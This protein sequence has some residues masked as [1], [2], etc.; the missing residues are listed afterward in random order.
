VDYPEFNWS[1][2]IE[3][4]TRAAAPDDEKKLASRLIEFARGQERV[5]TATTATLRAPVA[6]GI[7]FSQ[8]FADKLLSAEDLAAVHKAT[9]DDFVAYRDRHSPLDLGRSARKFEQSRAGDLR[10]TLR[11]WRVPLTRKK[12]K[13]CLTDLT[14]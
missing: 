13:D 3:A 6:A 2:P 7:S 12:I 8:A 5:V 9:V 10:N 1:V 11:C 4:M 14:N